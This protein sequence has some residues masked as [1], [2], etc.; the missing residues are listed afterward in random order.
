[1]AE[2]RILAGAGRW[3][4]LG[5]GGIVRLGPE[6]VAPD[7]TPRPATRQRLRE[8]GLYTLRPPDA[9]ALTVLT[10]TSCNLGCGYCFQ[11]TG[12]DPA[13][14]SRPPRIPRARLTSAA[15]TS[16]LRFAAGQMARARLGRLRLL[17]FGGEPL[18]NPAG[19]TELLERAADHGMTSAWMISTL[20]LL[21]RPLARRLAARGLTAV[22]VTFD[23]DRADHDR[24]RARRAG[25]GTFDAITGNI[26]RASEVAPLRWLLRVNVSPANQAGVDALIDRLAAA[27]DPARATVS[28]ACRVPRRGPAR[29]LPGRRRRAGPG[30]P[31]HRLASPGDRRRLLGPR[32]GARLPCQTCGY[33]RGR[34]G[35]VVSADGTLSSCWDTAGQPGWEVGTTAGGYRPEAEIAGRW[36]ACLDRRHGAAEASALAVAQDQIDAAVL[37]HLWDAG[38]LRALRG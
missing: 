17:L 11:N 6:H 35:A 15:I 38:K 8:L 34:Y 7:G 21:T 28:F 37:D 30:R 29:G 31:V 22:Q 16:A 2:E 14:G 3:W 4:F 24:I 18:L 27:V 23:G 32:P 36:V 25:G 5:P 26:A 10:S 12:Q 1:V 19:C 20:T 13:G 9:Y 33:P